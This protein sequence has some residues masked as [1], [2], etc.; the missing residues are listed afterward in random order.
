[1][2]IFEND[3][4]NNF[5]KV[6]P[7]INQLYVIVEQNTSPN[8]T[9]EAL[10]LTWQ[11]IDRSGAELIIKKV[12]EQ[13]ANPNTSTPT[14]DEMVEQTEKFLQDMKDNKQIT[15]SKPRKYFSS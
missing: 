5:P 9:L 3:V 6:F 8:A 13:N 11:L 4:Q 2:Y 14:L 15:V 7:L 12:R 1:M 10:N